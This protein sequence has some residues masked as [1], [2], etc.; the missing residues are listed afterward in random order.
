MPKY[1]EDFIL[2]L[3]FL[4]IFHINGPRSFFQVLGMALV[5]SLAAT[6]WP[7][8]CR[9]FERRRALSQADKE[10]VAAL[11]DFNQKSLGAFLVESC[12]KAFV[13]LLGLVLG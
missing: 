1:I 11:S 7:S 5:N 13:F 2:A 8:N 4:A 9:L 10:E 12:H 3:A 6:N